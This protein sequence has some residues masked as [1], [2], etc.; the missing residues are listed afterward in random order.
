MLGDC[1]SF[2]SSVEKAEH[3]EYKDRPLVVAGEPERRSGIVLAACP[4]AKAKGITTAERLGEAVA[5]CP[6]LVVIKPRMQRYIDV[7][8]L[9]TE[10]YKQYT[11][12]V[13]PNSID[14]Q[15]FDVTGSWHLFAD[16]PEEMARIIQNHVQATTGVY[17]RFGVGE[18]TSSDRQ[19]EC[20]AEEWA[21]GL[22]IAWLST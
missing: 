22:P 14:E 8:M 20:L 10:I 19:I 9:I 12:L 13:E 2:Y 4:F 15:F 11:D 7:S 17:T 16:T 6:E 18:F 21:P 3:P 5:K 1:E